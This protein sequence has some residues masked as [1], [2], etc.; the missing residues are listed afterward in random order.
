MALMMKS[1]ELMGIEGESILNLKMNKQL[2]KGRSPSIMILII[3]NLI[4]IQ[5]KTLE[6]ETGGLR[7]KIEDEHLKE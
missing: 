4:E 6:E 3:Q 5:M 2:K 7:E 1:N